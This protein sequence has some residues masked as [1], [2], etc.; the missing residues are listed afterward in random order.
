MV[1][2]VNNSLEVLRLAQEEQLYQKLLQQL[3]KDFKLANIQ[4]NIPEGIS[5]VDLKRS[6]HEKVYFLLVERFDA[7]LNLLYVVD[8]QESEVRKITAS[9]AVDLAKEIC[10]LILKR[11][12]VKVW[13][14]NQYSR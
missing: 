4:I 11:E 1:P 14:K 13:F 9:D 12:W 10:F 6:I 7:Y 3:D 5:P 8:I 2:N